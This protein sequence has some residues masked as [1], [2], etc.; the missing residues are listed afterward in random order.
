MPEDD[1]QTTD[2][3]TTDAGAAGTDDS[4]TD[5]TAADTATDTTDWKAMARKHER[6]AK[7]A[8]DALAAREKADM[9]EQERAIE[10]ARDEGRTEAAKTA[11]VRLASAEVR[12]A[13]TGI[14]TD[15]A[16]IAEDLDLTKLLDD[17]GEVDSEKVAALKA[18][19]VALAPKG[20][21]QPTSGVQGEPIAGG[22]PTLDEQI[23]A[24]QKAGD[25]TKVI[26]LNNQKL[27]ALAGKT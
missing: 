18:K 11:G 23:A 21:V 17:D 2:D 10:A 16:A 13:L 9:T 8:R 15:P 6:A 22:D 26:S 14:V 27:A 4:Q 20:A 5:D 19:Y 1:D 12:A 3:A 24:A 25:V 7:Q